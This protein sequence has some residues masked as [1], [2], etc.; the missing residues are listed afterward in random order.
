[1]DYWWLLLGVV[2]LAAGLFLL[3]QQFGVLPRYVP[4]G[5]LLLVLSG[6]LIVIGDLTRAKR[7]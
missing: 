2:A 3:L 5:G 1:M 4:A 7:Q 6:L